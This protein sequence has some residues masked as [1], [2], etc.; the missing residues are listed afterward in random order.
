[1]NN[2]LEK[3]TFRAQM[4]AEEAGVGNVYISGP[5]TS[6]AWDDFNETDSLQVRRELEKV[7][8]AQTLNIYIDSPGGYLDEGMTMMRLIKEHKA[9]TKN[10]Y[11]MECASAATLLCIPCD[12]V[13]AYEGAEFLF[14]MPR[15][16]MSGTPREIITYGQGL[17]KRAQSVAELYSAR[18]PGKTVEDILQM[19]EEETWMTPREAMECGFID[20]IEPI[21]PGSGATMSAQ[22]TPEDGALLAKLIGY[23]PRM[24]KPLTSADFETGESA[25]TGGAASRK[26]K[27]KEDKG[28]MTLEE[29]KKDAPE[30][31][32]EI[33]Q[34]GREEGILQERARMKALDAIGDEES[35]E[36][37]EEAKYGENPMTA[38]EAAMAIL[39]QM[40]GKPK[41]E[42]RKGA[43]EGYMEK[44]RAETAQMNRVEAGAAGDNDEGDED[45]RAM[46]REMAKAQ[47]AY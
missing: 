11:C 36:L 1:M 4:S 40:R 10:A 15:G 35:R 21:A 27:D 37:I 14:H 30:L 34:A 6:W 32:E 23:K 3:L 39:T 28:T 13:T 38:P 26:D 43:G 12:R 9:K 44:R 18:M 45:I 31:V 47:R 19:M 2:R 29:L 33:M 46:A 20:A 25:P 42:S 22:R 8:D 24:A 5:I 17:E 7:A 41:G 16:G